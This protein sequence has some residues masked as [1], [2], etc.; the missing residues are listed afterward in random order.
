MNSTRRFAFQTVVALLA[1]STITGAGAAEDPARFPSRPLRIVVGF[2]P[3]Q[4]SDI[5]ARLYADALSK[6]LDQSVIVENRPGG[7]ATLAADY[8]ARAPADGYTIYYGS[9]GPMAIAPN[10]YPRLPYDPIKDFEPV[11]TGGVVPMVLVVAADAPYRTLADLVAAGRGDKGSSINYGSS[12]SGGTAHLTMEMLKLASGTKFT[13]VPYKGSSAVLTDLMGHSVQ[14]AFDTTGG[15]QSFLRSGT[16]RALGVGTT[17]RLADM[18]D[19]PSIS[20]SFPGF[21]AAA[22]G[23]FAVPKGTPAPIVQKLTTQFDALNAAPALKEKLATQSM[24]ISSTPTSEMKPFM[25]RE[26]ETWGK[27]VKASGATVD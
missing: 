25:Q 16:L 2:P 13:H 18:P 11:G 19:V 7:A 17:F 8:V 15:T 9:T 24:V 22:W 23:V 5:V 27:A 4:S 3:G 14:V 26:I 12:G 21:Q 6:A 20:E 10:L 1:L